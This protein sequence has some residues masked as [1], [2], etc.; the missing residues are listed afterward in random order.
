MKFLQMDCTNITAYFRRHNIPTMTVRELFDFITDPLLADDQVDAY[1][2]AIQDKISHRS[3][4]LTNQQQVPLFLYSC[5]CFVESKSNKP[6]VY[7]E[8]NRWMRK[9]SKILSFQGTLAKCWTTKGTYRR[10]KKETPKMYLF[11][12]ISL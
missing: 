2:E 12:V 1:L 6:I 3:S 9:Y 8:M 5:L 7:T 11:S 10:Y 4:S